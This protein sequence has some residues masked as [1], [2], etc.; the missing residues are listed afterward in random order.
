MPRGESE[1]GALG[2]RPVGE[3]EVERFDGHVD[4]LGERRG[5]ALE[6][7][8][9]ADGED[10][11]GGAGREVL[12]GDA[13]APPAEREGAAAQ[14]IQAEPPERDEQVVAAHARE[15]GQREPLEDALEA[16]LGRPGGVAAE[17][18]APAEPPERSTQWR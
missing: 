11:L 15:A 5:A 9:I 16:P 7:Q 12:A 17:G 1:R 3:R 18:L 6:Q 8:R 10:A 4:R 13:R 2:G 14:L